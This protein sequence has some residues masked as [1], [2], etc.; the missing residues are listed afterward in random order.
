M[1]RL[2]LAL[3]LVV[4]ACGSDPTDPTA[5]LTLSDT[6]HVLVPAWNIACRDVTECR[7]SSVQRRWPTS[8]FNAAGTACVEGRCV[9]V[10]DTGISANCDG[11]ID[12]GCEVRT[13][14]CP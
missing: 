7:A 9:L 14:T 5:T 12:N 1:T 11:N 13:T 3:A 8:A 6:Q 10:C 2:A 4:A